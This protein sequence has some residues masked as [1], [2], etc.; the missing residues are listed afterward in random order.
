MKISKRTLPGRLKKALGKMF[1]EMGFE[2][3]VG[4]ERSNL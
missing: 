3:W 2:G 1:F 4:F